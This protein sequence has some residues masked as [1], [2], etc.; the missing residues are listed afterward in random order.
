MASMVD[1]LAR[2]RK[3][4]DLVDSLSFNGGPT[5]RAEGG[6][7]LHPRTPPGSARFGIERRVP[8]LPFFVGVE[9]LITAP[10]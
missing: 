7:A 4:G 2:V 5:G 9:M 1:K 10:R 8:L 3:V 6:T